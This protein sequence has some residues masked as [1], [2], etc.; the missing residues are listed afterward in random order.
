VKIIL[1]IATALMTGA[2]ALSSGAA[3][4]AASPVLQS[5][6]AEVQKD[7]EDIRAYCRDHLVNANESQTRVPSGDEGLEVFTVSGVQ[8]VMIDERELCDGWLQRR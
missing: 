8:A 5:L 7:I 2:Y 6:P 4:E 3:Q 1:M